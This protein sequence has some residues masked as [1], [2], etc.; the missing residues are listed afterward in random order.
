M[1]TIS[2][3]TE[4]GTPMA[5][6]LTDLMAGF[7]NPSKGLKTAITNVKSLRNRRKV[8]ALICTLITSLRDAEE[9][10]MNNMPENLKNSSRYDDADERLEKLDEVIDIIGDIYTQ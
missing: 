4:A 8:M 10:F 7:T 1:G 6:E 2:S 5:S 9:E 3:N